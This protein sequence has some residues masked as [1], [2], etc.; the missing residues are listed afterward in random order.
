MKDLTH[1]I[2]LLKSPFLF[3]WIDSEKMEN[4]G[5][6]FMLHQMYHPRQDPQNFNM[7][8]QPQNSNLGW[9]QIG[10]KAQKSEK[11]QW[12]PSCLS[13]RTPQG[14]HSLL[15]S[16]LP[17]W[18]GFWWKDLFS[19]ERC[20]D[21]ATL[22]PIRLIAPITRNCIRPGKCLII[23][24][25]WFSLEGIFFFFCFCVCVCVQTS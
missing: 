7:L 15:S 22:A 12:C 1:A 14:Q 5:S 17:N 3:I 2:I 23:L 13:D 21:N 10:R 9:P 24:R 11:L 6:P 4:L 8:D 20:G 16:D 25:N 18:S 19:G